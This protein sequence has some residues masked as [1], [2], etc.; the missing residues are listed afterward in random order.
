[1][2][3]RLASSNG[4]KV[5]LVVFILTSSAVFFPLVGSES[6]E[7]K[8][9]SGTA[10]FPYPGDDWAWEMIGTPYAHRINETG[11]D[12]RI[13][14]IDT[15][16]DHTHPDL[17]DKMWT[18]SDEKPDN[19]MDD[20]GNGYID[21]YH[22][23][24]FVDDD[25]DPMDEHGHGTHV[26]GIISSIA[27]EA[28]L[29]ALRVIEEQGG[30]WIDL[31]Q[32]IEYAR[33]NGADIIT[34]SLGSK[35]STL[36]RL[37]EMQISAAYEEGIL[38]TAA[39]GNNNESEKFYPAGYE[40]VISVSA[41]NSTKQ[42]AYYSNYGDWIELAAPGGGTEK[43]V[44]S[45]LPNESYGN[46]I[47][48]SMACPFVTGSAALRFS[49]K[50]GETNVDVRNFM[51]DT[52]IDL[53]NEQYYGHGLVNAYRAAGGEVPTSVQRLESD[54]GDSIVN[55]SWDDPWHEGASQIDGFRI[56]RGEYEQ[57]M[58]MIEEVGPEQNHYEDISVENDLTYQY[59]VTAINDNGEGLESE[60]VLAT[61]RG[62]P[63]APSEPRD[64]A[65]ELLEGG[66]ELTWENPIDDGGS[67]L[68]NYNIYRKTSDDEEMTWIG[69]VD[70]EKTTYLD[71]T[72]LPE[73][74]Y[75]Y[76]VTAESDVGESEPALT[77]SIPVPETFEPVL[78]EPT[79]PK[80]ISA[81]LTDE[82]VEIRWE[83]PLE[84]GG[85]PIINYN[86]YR[87]ETGKED[88]FELIG[89]TENGTFRYLDDSIS[90]DSDYTYSVT[91]ENEVGESSMS[92]SVTVAVPEDEVSS[93]LIEEINI[94]FAILLIIVFGVMISLLIALTKLVNS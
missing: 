67:N 31:A 33:D 3:K 66:V 14:V 8:E 73:K 36:G 18:N 91:A 59:K 56:Y 6:L 88:E 5:L 60:V 65:G 28:E 82:G 90:S 11:E 89:E 94:R 84:D 4:T 71:E 78:T 42:K 19:G 24:D 23:Y 72:V 20:D 75:T 15:G 63:V 52:A 69:K 53:G 29:M 37:I 58:E 64:V 27:P 81:E 83:E 7:V 54:P 22:G 17:E 21:D 26:A 76:G 57:G 16:I 25:P 55:L 2:K 93:G 46:L 35:K 9:V 48:T 13:A 70:K 10:E 40:E 43:R 51:Q 12:V 86:I 30:D 79:S 34:M 62:E 92:R 44:Y 74:E 38:L 50:P 41:V 45:T 39:A 49:A 68:T 1:M 87:N 80:E 77:E 85:S 32:A 61:P 47:G